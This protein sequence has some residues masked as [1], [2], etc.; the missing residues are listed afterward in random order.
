MQTN[1]LSNDL[2]FTSNAALRRCNRVRMPVG[3]Q[4]DSRTCKLR[5]VPS[6]ALM[7]EQSEGCVKRNPIDNDDDD[8]EMEHQNGD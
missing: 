1:L 4:G 7:R 6:A 3:Q 2:A 8:D 5:Q